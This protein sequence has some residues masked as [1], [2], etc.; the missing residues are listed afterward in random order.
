MK[1]FVLSHKEYSSY[2]QMTI[3]P[4][5][6]SISVN[7]HKGE[8]IEDKDR[9]GCSIEFGDRFYILKKVSLFPI[10]SDVDFIESI[11][12]SRDNT[13]KI[14]KDLLDVV[15]YDIATYIHKSRRRDVEGDIVSDVSFPLDIYMKSW[16]EQL[17]HCISYTKT[18]M[19]YN[20]KKE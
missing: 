3:L 2:A 13:D 6:F 17:N 16:Q 19:N 18:R 15:I 5:T 1:N 12:H 7:F 4:S 14:C 20:P 11:Y 10:D 8:D 9:I